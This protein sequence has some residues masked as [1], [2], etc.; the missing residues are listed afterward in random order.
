MVSICSDTK[1]RKK[2][3]PPKPIGWNKKA[4]YEKRWRVAVQM[5]AF[6]W[7]KKNPLASKSTKKRRG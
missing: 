6:L 7:N 4:K 3:N 5:Y 2:N 1:I